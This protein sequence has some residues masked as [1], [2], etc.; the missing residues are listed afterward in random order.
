[1]RHFQVDLYVGHEVKNLL[2]GIEVG[3]DV[4]D[5]ESYVDIGDL[6]L[7][8]I[9]LEDKENGCSTTELES[10][11]HCRGHKCALCNEF[12][13][14][15][16]GNLLH[17]EGTLYGAKADVPQVETIL[18]EE[19]VPQYG[20]LAGELQEYPVEVECSHLKEQ[21]GNLLQAYVAWYTQNN[22]HKRKITYKHT[23]DAA[24]DNM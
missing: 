10:A 1:M 14:V 7:L 16:Q 13:Q 12:L 15:V 22:M 18:A 17:A 20:T 8:N 4:V 2:W 6:L 9:H 19:S 21:V 23:L 5:Y 24:G 11:L 3:L